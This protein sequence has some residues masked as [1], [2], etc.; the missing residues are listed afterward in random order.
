MAILEKT[1]CQEHYS[2][3]NYCLHLNTVAGRAVD[4]Y[5]IDT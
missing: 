4:V 3:T 1:V 5:I 2:V